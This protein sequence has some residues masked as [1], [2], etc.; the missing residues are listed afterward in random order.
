M[1]KKVCFMLVFYF[2]TVFGYREIV[3]AATN[4]KDKSFEEGLFE[5]GYKPVEKALEDFEQ[6]YKRKL[7]LPLRI[8]P[9][10]F[11]HI[12]GRFSD[13]DGDMN[14]TFEIMF[15]SDKSP[16]N[17]YKIDVRPTKYRIRITNKDGIKTYGLNDGKKAYYIATR[18][19]NL[20]IFEKDNWQYMI[21]IDK[22]ISDKISAETLVNIANSLEYQ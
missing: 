7:E 20:L 15:I 21:G 18:G 22:R 17:H 5:I 2:L 1:N 16:E 6:H 19:S 10:A 13:L 11:T 12:L 8:P 9:V 4:E 3:S 14:D